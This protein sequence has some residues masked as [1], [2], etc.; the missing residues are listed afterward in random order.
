MEV[1]DL[2]HVIS[3]VANHHNPQ[4]KS[5]FPPSKTLDILMILH[6][7]LAKR[8]IATQINATQTPP[9]GCVRSALGPGYDYCGV[10]VPI[11]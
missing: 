5:P 6:R 9:R 2:Q 3:L 7:R 10:S 4:I 11:D 1:R 8:G